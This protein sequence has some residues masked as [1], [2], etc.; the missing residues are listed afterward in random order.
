[1]NKNQ[2][3]CIYPYMVPYVHLGAF[4]LY[5]NYRDKYYLCWIQVF[6]GRVE[7]ITFPSSCV[8]FEDLIYRFLK[9]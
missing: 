5:V 6:A 3:G 4:W 7:A 9:Y 8:D 2:I 1:M